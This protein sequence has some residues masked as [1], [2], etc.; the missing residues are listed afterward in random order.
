MTHRVSERIATPTSV[1]LMASNS[2]IAFL[3][4]QF[5]TQDVDQLTWDL[6]L[7]CV[8]VVVVGAPIGAII[9]SH[10]HRLT[11][12]WLVYILDTAQLLGA[13]I[14]LQPWTSKHTSSPILL[15]LSSLLLMCLG[16]SYFSILAYYGQ[17]LLNNI[18]DCDDN[19]SDINSLDDSIIS[20]LADST[21]NASFLHR[22][23]SR[24][25]GG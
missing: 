25:G 22:V 15:S 13:L 4:K 5:I 2:I 19:A 23:K 9:S 16:L 7:C 6:W 17:K 11:L 21:S 18:S 24:N 3:W 20:P 12:A 8:P 1:L 14:I 10:F